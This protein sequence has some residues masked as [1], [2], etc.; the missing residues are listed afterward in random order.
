MIKIK[1]LSKIYNP[2]ELSRT[3]ALDNVSF[4]VKKGEIVSIIGKTGSG[5]TTLAS[6][7]IGLTK[8]T[9]GEIELN[10][11]IV[12]N[13]KS[14]KKELRKITNILLSS[15]QYP[16]HQLFT[17]TVKDE[18]LFNNEDK[19]EEMLSLMKVMG[20]EKSLLDKSP[21]RISSGQKRKVILIALLLNNPEI[22]VLDEPTAF[23]DPRS[24]RDFVETI[25]TINKKFKT[26]IVFISH[27]MEDI[28]NVSEKSLLLHEGKQIMFD[29]T[30]KVVETYL[31][32]DYYGK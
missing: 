17:P 26:T 5:K 31:G 14:K 7:L 2:K 1:E 30:S 10:N 21:F 25:K 22:L 20:L 29:K 28:S 13:K 24:R 19:E 15:F 8:P 11:E 9:E 32:G 4:E 12:I 18:M 27:N 6:L 23:L 16:D 3:V